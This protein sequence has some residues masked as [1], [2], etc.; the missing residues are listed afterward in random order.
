MVLR[1]GLR[2][3]WILGLCLVASNSLSLP[4]IRD[5]EFIQQCVDI[6][7]EMRG[8]VSPPA[9]DMKHM[10][11]EVK[12]A[13]LAKSW[14]DKCKYE[15][16]VCLPK[17]YG[18]HPDFDHVGENIWLGSL[19]IFSPRS[20][21]IGWYNETAFYN[22]D[23][24]SCSSL[25]SHYTQVVWAT[26]YKVGCAATMCPNLGKSQTVIFVCNYSPAGNY[27]NQPPYTKGKF[28]SMC[29]EKEVCVKNLCS[30]QKKKKA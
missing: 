23:T 12:L 9:A 6:H 24:L 1:E 28:C 5:R 21:V 2:W 18:C 11:W 4:S 14:A 22:F 30:K 26:S 25:C 3:L 15:H 16:N 27:L 17:R 7:N 19:R 10:V 20:A 13:K 8:K 29:E